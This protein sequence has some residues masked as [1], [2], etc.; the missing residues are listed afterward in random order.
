MLLVRGHLSLRSLISMASIKSVLAQQVY[1]YHT[2]G[3]K[4][5]RPGREPMPMS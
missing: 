2:Y 4:L 1:I 5:E 3:E